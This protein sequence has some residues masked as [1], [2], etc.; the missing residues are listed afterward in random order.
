MDLSRISRWCVE[1]DSDPL[2]SRRHRGQTI[3]L[4]VAYSGPARWRNHCLS[5]GSNT[6]QRQIAAPRCYKSKQVSDTV[7]H[8]Y[9]QLL[10]LSSQPGPAVTTEIR[11]M[12]LSNGCLASDRQTLKSRKRIMTARLTCLTRPLSPPVAVCDIIFH[13]NTQ[14]DGIQENRK[15]AGAEVAMT[16]SAT[17]RVTFGH[18]GGNRA[19][20][21]EC[22][23]DSLRRGAQR[24]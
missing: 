10:Q 24:T 16:E 7:G 14:I 13:I 4:R 15:S 5:Q 8:G 1:G 18:D 2:R 22:D 9:G 20:T 21:Q 3:W 19:G 12:Q 11:R 6:R 23:A 17:I